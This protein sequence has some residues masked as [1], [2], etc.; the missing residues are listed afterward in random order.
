MFDFHASINI[1]D[2]INSGQIFLWENYKNTW[3]I[4][5]GHNIIVVNQKQFEN[6]T[7]TKETKKFFRTDDDI[8]KILKNITRDKIVKK[9]VKHY[10]GLRITRQDPFQCCISF[11]VSS[12]SNI[13]NI[14][15]RLKKLCI[16]FGTKVRFKNESFFYFLHPKCLQMLHCKIYKNVN[17]DIDQNMF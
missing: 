1:H 5:N 10:P 4:V 12:N 14:R 11:I 13:P 9:A 15:M 6:V 3:F 17:W 8:K 2:T 16:K 7:L